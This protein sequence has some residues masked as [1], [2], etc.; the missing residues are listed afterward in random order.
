MYMCIKSLSILYKQ[1]NISIFVIDCNDAEPRLYSLKLLQSLC[2]Q[3]DNNQLQYPSLVYMFIDLRVS[4]KQETQ[5]RML[6]NIL[7]HVVT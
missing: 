1:L 2:V 4:G 7:N 6:L 3:N 5:R